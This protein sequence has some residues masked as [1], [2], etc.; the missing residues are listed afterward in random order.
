MPNMFLFMLGRATEPLCTSTR[1]RFASSEFFSADNL[2]L[3][4]AVRDGCVL[5]SLTCRA[6]VDPFNDKYVLKFMR[7]LIVQGLMCKVGL[8]LKQ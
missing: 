8:D 1:K 5:L 7:Q 2:M 6:F 4:N 3:V